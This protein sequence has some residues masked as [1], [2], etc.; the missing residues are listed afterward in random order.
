M[1]VF[2]STS[3]HEANTHTTLGYNGVFQ[4]FLE[5]KSKKA[6]PYLLYNILRGVKKNKMYTSN[7]MRN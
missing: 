2:L 5:I 7:S 4:S 6:P 3:A 1:Y